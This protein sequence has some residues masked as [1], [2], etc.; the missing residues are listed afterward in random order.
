MEISWRFDE[1]R[2][3][4]ELLGNIG[5]SFPGPN[6]A[7]HLEKDLERL[8][9]REIWESWWEN[10]P[11]NT[12]DSDG[13]ELARASLLADLQPLFPE[14][15]P[16]WQKK[17]ERKVFGKAEK[18][19]TV[20]PGIVIMVL[21][22]LNRMF[23]SENA[24]DYLLDSLETILA[25]VPLEQL[26]SDGSK[27][28]HYMSDWRFRLDTARRHIGLLMSEREMAKREWSKHQVSRYWGLL[29]WIDEPFSADKLPKGKLLGLFSRKEAPPRFRPNSDDVFIAY[30]KGVATKDDLYDTLIGPRD[31]NVSW[32]R[33]YRDL[34]D[35]SG[36]KPGPAAKRFPF[37][38]EFADNCRERILQV[39]KK[40][41][42]LPTPASS[43]ALALKH[44]GGTDVFLDFLK[45]LG[46]ET[47]SR[48]WT[49]DQKSKS[50]VFS[51]I[52]RATYPSKEDDM[53]T[54]KKKAKEMKIKEAR[55][56][57][58]AVYAPQWS[59]HVEATL[60][61]KGFSSG[62]WWIHAHT[63]DSRWTVDDDIKDAWSAETS[64]YTPLEAQDLLDGAVDVKW[65]EKA[66]EALGEKRWKK[67]EN[68]AKYSSGGAGHVRAK[69]FAEAMTGRLKKEDVKKRITD[70]RHQD[71]VRALGLLPLAEGEEREEDLMDRYLFFQEFVRT[72]KKFGAQ[73]KNSERLAM[74]IGMENLA[75]TAG[76]KDPLRMEWD[77]EARSVQDLAIAMPSVSVDDTTVGLAI[78]ESGAPRVVVE[79]N[80][81]ALKSVPAKL[82]KN[83][84]VKE[85]RQ[86]AADLKRQSSRMRKSLEQSMCRGDVFTAEDLKSFENHPLLSPVTGKLLFTTGDKTG[87]PSRKDCTLLDFS[88]N[89][90]ELE[91]G[92]QL[93]IAHPCDLAK[94]GDWSKWQ[95]E[96]FSSKRVQPF[97]QIFRELYVLTESEKKEGHASRRY[98]GHQVQAKMTAALLGA[99]GW[100]LH[101]EEGAVKTFHDEK[102]TAWLSFLEGILTPAEVEGPTVESVHF[103][104]PGDW[105]PLKLVDIPP[106]VFSEVMRDVDLVVSVAHAGGVDPEASASTVEMRAALAKETCSLLGFE[107]VRFEGS[108]VLIDGKLSSYSVHLGSAVVHRMPGG[109]LFIVPVHSQHRGRIFLPFADDDPKTAEVMSK[110]IMLAQDDT[111]KDPTILEQFRS[112]A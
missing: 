51:H 49:Y 66:F 28:Y 24:V 69:L 107:N 84:E 15:V 73:R 45:A 30:E 42:D 98:E 48:G 95:E 3:K 4:K 109:Q 37:A 1:D 20:Y 63:K 31:E 9:L 61:W 99:R 22:W 55:L 59:G 96:C 71:S 23:S 57:D 77:L 104:R 94:T 60:G 5:R 33:S 75:R 86:R 47:F 44:T 32:L 93:R 53:E 68:S 97:K 67:L 41:G 18:C 29:R 8:P 46:A 100:V 102:I 92:E 70:K 21:S 76:Y 103:T 81:Q 11:D 64:T 110:V 89:R 13:L 112:I 78:D 52:V 14:E 91:K 19:K 36:R 85:I 34:H 90:I 80:G 65:F 56:I 74:K 83:K 26:R 82:K 6:L 87:Y 79:K 39:E 108:H 50:S 2:T 43:P 101:P 72:G 16:G 54:F 7:L 58:A 105:R 106:L 10:R 62:V 35:L 40:R 12:R 27:D 88:G 17:I 38:K 111:I 25:E